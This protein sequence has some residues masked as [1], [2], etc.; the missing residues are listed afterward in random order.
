MTKIILVAVTLG[1]LCGYL[2]LPESF[3]GNLNT[4]STIA[5]NF[6]I[7]SVGIDVGS[8]KNLLSDLKKNGIGI[9]LIPICIVLG[10]LVGGL[11]TALIYGLPLKSSLSIASGFGWYSLS[12][13]LLTNLENA[14]V[15]T[16]AFLTNVFREL[17]AVI[18][19]PILATKLNHYTAI[20]P[21]GATS[22][23]TTLPLIAK[24]TTPQ[25]AV[26]SFLNGAILTSLVPI[27]ITFFYTL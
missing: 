18:L 4:L 3:I 24:A 1:M 9:I 5:L 26:V 17:I 19:I 20:A 15:G 14:Q 22:M 23:D 27:L 6:L 7:L 12:G 11:M 2:L 10:S 21:A 25:I 8:N 13:I 16:I